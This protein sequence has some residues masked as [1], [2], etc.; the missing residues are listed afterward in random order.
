MNYKTAC[1]S[2]PSSAG[3]AETPKETNAI[4]RIDV[5]LNQPSDAS[6]KPKQLA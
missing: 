5:S 4:R 6:H 3:F 2:N 1:L